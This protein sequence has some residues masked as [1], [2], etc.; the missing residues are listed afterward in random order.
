M[1]LVEF[2]K[3]FDTSHILYFLEMESHYITSIFQL[4]G[5]S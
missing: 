5:T 4:L 3:T 2:D 1:T